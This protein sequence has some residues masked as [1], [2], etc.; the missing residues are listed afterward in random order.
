MKTQKGK[1]K[2]RQ[3]IYYFNSLYNSMSK[4]IKAISLA[5]FFFG[6]IL[7]FYGD[8]NAQTVETHIKIT[9]D[10]P[11]IISVEG[12]FSETNAAARGNNLSFVQSYAGA[13]N[14]GARISD[15]NLTD[16]NGRRVAYRTLQPGEFLAERNFSRWQYRINAEL[17]KN[18]AAAAHVSSLSDEQAV[19]MF[20]DLLPEFAEKTGAKITLDLPAGWKIS[21][22]EVKTGENTFAADNLEK[23]VFYVGKNLREREIAADGGAKINLITEGENQFSDDEAARMTAEIF[24]YYVK[25]FGSSPPP[26]FAVFLGKFEGEQTFG[27]WEAETRGANTTIF[28]AGMWFKNQSLQLLHEQLRHEIFHFWMPNNL[29]LSGSYDWFYEGFALYQ[30]LRT[31][32]AT[33]RI[34]FDDF[35]DTLARA[36]TIDNFQDQRI[37]LLEASKNR[38]NAGANTQIY[39]RGMLVAFLCD[40]AVLQKSKGKHSLTDILRQIYDKYSFPNQ[41]TDG[42]T[43]VLN[44]LQSRAELKIIIE[45]YIGGAE[46]IDWKNDLSAV[47]IES[48]EE[49]LAV[50]LRIKSKL[51]GREKDLLDKLGYNNWRKLSPNLR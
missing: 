6:C 14:L 29:N 2:L 49:N 11:K 16:M 17:P 12:K 19:L 8:C 21:T 4:Q 32:V 40:I 34:R 33:N 23:A 47:G 36:Q 42:N 44:V 35:L 26:H 39:A 50:K 1:D 3:V 27:R 22:T 48:G 30:A 28:S 46:K 9:A 43:A 38:W 10:S 45:K 31:G 24:N 51:N 41:R 15:L 5:A 13:E 18:S 20:G 7:Q 37:S 25:F